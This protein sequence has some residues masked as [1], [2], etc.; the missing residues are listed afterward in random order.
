[1]LSV[2]IVSLPVLTCAQEKH[3]V[4]PVRGIWMMGQSLGDG[5][6]SLP[7]VTPEDTG[8]GNYSFLRGVRT[9]LAGDHGAA[10]E[11]RAAEQFAF[12]PL[13]AAQ[14]SS[15][16]ETVAN[17]LADHLKA[18]LVRRD[19]MMPRNEPPHFLVAFAGQGGRQI[20]ELAKADLST[21]PRTPKVKAQ[22]GG[23]YR[24][25]LDDARRAMQEARARGM[26]F[27]VAA[28]YWMQGEG[29][30]GATGGIHPTRWDPELP[31]PAGQE[32]YRDQLMAYRRQWSADLCAI[33]GQRGDLPMFTYQTLGPAGGAQLMAADA[34]PHLWMVGPHYAVPSA[35]NSRR[36]PGQH[37]DAIHLSADGERWW[38]EQVGKVMHRVLHEKEDWQPLRPRAAW[39]DADLQGVLVEFTTPRP[40]LV[41]DTTF[42]PRQQRSAPGGCTSLMG[43]TVR[44]RAGV[45]LPLAAVTTEGPTR[46]RLRLASALPERAR[47]T[48]EYGSPNAGE[49]GII[50]SLEQGQPR[51][52]QSTLVMVLEGDHSQMLQA[53]MDEGA[54]FVSNTQM[55]A[56]TLTR[57]PVR[58]VTVEDG[59]TR[60]AFEARE[61]R[62]GIPFQAG[63]G[64]VA[65]RPFSYGNLRDSD[66]EKS[67]HVFADHGYGRRA[68]QPYPLW[69]WCVLFSGLE[70]SDTPPAA[71]A[72][73]TGHQGVSMHMR[74]AR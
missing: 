34:D 25:S 50:R 65:Q 10:P 19:K 73:S 66:S 46:L 53:L 74:A 56:A 21:D 33:T 32:W 18:A 47:L 72:A 27:E 45:V 24:T 23:Y 41:L 36:P 15:L 29:N 38:G 37:G 70:V 6:E 57:A 17:G 59:F 2:S 5:S 62:N 3:A 71:D 68:G 43:F 13:K 16:G 11:Q 69:N 55:D 63:Q 52:G 4:A 7:L 67:V 35:I 42:L 26:T 58:A 39:L 64:V 40:P 14:N 20:Q 60:L 61:L 28:L 12:M 48:L 49:L 8:W 1:M 51:D 22:G 54:F 9:W 31:R 44:T 30:G